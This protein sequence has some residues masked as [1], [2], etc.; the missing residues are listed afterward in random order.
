MLKVFIVKRLELQ[1]KSSIMCAQCSV[2]NWS[3]Y[4]VG[5]GNKFKF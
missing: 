3:L 4:K 2:N 5:K 1:L